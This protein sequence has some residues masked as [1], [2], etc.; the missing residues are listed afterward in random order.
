MRTIKIYDRDRA[1][2]MKRDELL[3]VKRIQIE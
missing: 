1:Y 2:N 3:N